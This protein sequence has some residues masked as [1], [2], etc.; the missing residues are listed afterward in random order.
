MLFQIVLL[1][2]KTVLLVEQN[3]YIVT[4]VE[5]TH[6]GR[7]EEDAPICP[8]NLQSLSFS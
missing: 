3:L 8:G 7:A 4:T 2:A 5:G 6:V 1:L